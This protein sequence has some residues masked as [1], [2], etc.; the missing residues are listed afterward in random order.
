MPLPA[1]AILELPLAI[2]QRDCDPVPLA[3]LVISKQI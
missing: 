3:Q 2:L 1:M